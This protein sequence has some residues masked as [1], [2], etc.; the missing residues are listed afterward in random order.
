MW[1]AA[2]CGGP[3]AAVEEEIFT[4]LAP[5]PS[6]PG[7]PPGR[8][9]MWDELG[10]GAPA[11]Q[12]GAPRAPAGPPSGLPPG[13]PPE[14]FAKGGA[15]AKSSSSFLD[16]WLAKRKTGGSSRAP[17][18]PARPVAASTPWEK[19]PADSKK[20]Q[21]P[22]QSP[23]AQDAGFK[24]SR[25]AEHTF[26]VNKPDGPKEHTVRIDKDGNLTSAK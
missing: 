2:K 23:Q 14:V 13:S 8:R 16:E 15:S 9:P 20:P 17:M 6:R 24:V 26:H 4:R 21:P 19:P 11:G 3:G 12:A 5:Q 18:P 7:L 10:L 25:A 22:A 1:W